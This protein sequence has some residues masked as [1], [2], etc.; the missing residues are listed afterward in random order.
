MFHL[1]LKYG[2]YYYYTCTDA[3][4][5][6]DELSVATMMP[7]DHLSVTHK[8]LCITTLITYRKVC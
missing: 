2:G 4:R 6:A 5:F 8:K 7:E 3:Q 1:L